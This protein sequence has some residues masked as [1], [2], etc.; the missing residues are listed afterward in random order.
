MDIKMNK[1]AS[2]VLAAAV[3]SA[4]TAGS[5]NASHFRGAALVPSVSETGMVTVD[6]KSFWRTSFVGAVGN[7]SV[8][9]VLDS[10]NS[11][12]NVGSFGRTSVDPT[13]F[14]DS[15][16]AE[17]NE[18]Y[19]FRLPGAGLYTMS[20]DSCCWVSGVHNQGGTSRFGTTSMIYWDGSTANTPIQ[21]DLEN[22]QQQVIGG[23][24]YSDN[25][26]AVGSGL[27][28]DDTHLS[29][30]MTAQAR[31]FGIDATGQIT[32]DATSTG[33]YTDNTSNV[34]AD[35][36]FSGK[37]N[38]ADGSSIEFVWV[39]DTVDSTQAPNLAPE[40]TDVV[41][42]AL[43]GDTIDQTLQVS[44]PDGDPVTTS[45]LSFLGTGGAIGNST[46]DPSTLE[47]S[48]DSTGFGPGQYTAT[49]GASDGSLTDQG[50]ITINLAARPTG[51]VSE[52]SAL[53]IA[54]AGLLGLASLRRR[55]N[56][57]K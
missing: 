4:L 30:G 39:F 54:G 25:L 20:F 49:F 8:S 26:D 12:V 9:G 11:N 13:D 31:G 44:D 3:A 51:N 10:D 14:S 43:V 21:F 53:I 22:I 48:W 35:E 33:L 56:A 55:R 24:A 17:L 47:F 19:Q 28:Y 1:K 42:N 15:R 36:A 18:Q 40:I 6:A 34:G 29:T 27:T 57:K 38:S 23:V 46:F 41:I 32:I 5:A 37:I 16:R 52:P 45:F 7:V 50:T 2:L